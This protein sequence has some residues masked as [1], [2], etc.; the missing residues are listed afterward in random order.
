MYLAWAPF[1]SGAERALLMTLRSLD[2]AQCEPYVLAGT[3]GEFARQVRALGIRCDVLPILPLDRAKPVTSSLSLARVT[4][5]AWRF[6]PDVIHSNDMPSYQPGAYA[7]RLL[8]VPVVTHLRFPDSPEGYRWFFRAPPTLAIFISE[9]FKAEAVSAAPELF[10]NRATV[11]YD[12]VELPRIWTTDERT[13]RREALGL[14]RDRPIA[15]ITGQVSEVKGIR[16]FIE[17][18]DLLR[19]LPVHFA[20][21]GDDLRTHGAFRQEMEVTVARLGLQDRFTFLGFRS[22]A[23]EIVQAFDI[24]AVPSRVEP[25]GLASLEAMAAAL[26]VVASRV[27]GIPEVVRDDQD[28]ILV[29]PRDAKSLAIGIARL[30]K[31]PELGIAMG[32]RG[33]QRAADA[34][35]MRGHYDG[36]QAAYADALTRVQPRKKGAV[37]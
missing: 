3:D 7:A 11:V 18:A 4:A 14:P 6:R 35:C 23:P 8:R 10:K 5:A 1:F 37:A 16:E 26:P 2:L 25:F 19:D 29:P 24:V 30:V 21:L 32:R 22:D 28:G 27:G 15:A 20:V 31:S 17:A 13:A 33:R 36:I 34:F 12:A 9:S